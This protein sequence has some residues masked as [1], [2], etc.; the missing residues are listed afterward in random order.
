MT[1]FGWYNNWKCVHCDRCG[2]TDEQG[3]CLDDIEWVILE[4]GKVLI[5]KD[6]LEKIQMIFDFLNVDMYISN[7]TAIGQIIDDVTEKLKEVLT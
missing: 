1:D 4:K 6:T 5:D 7:T 3:N 2:N